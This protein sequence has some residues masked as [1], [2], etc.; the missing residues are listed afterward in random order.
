MN[1]L[2]HFKPDDIAAGPAKLDADQVNWLA[3]RPVFVGV[4]L[5]LAGAQPGEVRSEKAAFRQQ[6]D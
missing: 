6:V 1:A 3:Q 2:T 4:T 5:I